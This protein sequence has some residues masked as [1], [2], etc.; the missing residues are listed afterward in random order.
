MTET[1]HSSH[2]F[3]RFT[4]L[5]SPV[6]LRVAGFAL[7]VLCGAVVLS[8]LIVTSLGQLE[9]LRDDYAA[10]RGQRFY[11]GVTMRASIRTLNEKLLQY[12]LTK[13]PRF[14]EEFLSESAVLRE[15]IR[16][17]RFLPAGLADVELARRINFSQQLEIL[18]KA[19][20]DYEAY[21]AETSRIL[22]PGNQDAFEECYRVMRAA[23]IDFV[24]QCDDLEKAQAKGFSEFLTAT[25][26]T[27]R[28]QQLLLQLSS[29][30]VLVL[31]TGLGIM[32]YRGMIAPLQARLSQSQAIIER[33]Q[34]LASLG[35]LGSGVA[36]EIRNPLTAIKLRLFSLKKSFPSML[37]NEDAIVI[38]NEINRLERIVKDFLRFARPSDPELVRVEARAILQGVEHLLRSPLEHAQ[39][40][41][42]FQCEQSVFVRADPQQIM[43]ALINLVQNAAD[44]IG[45]QGRITLRCFREPVDWAGEDSAAVLSVEDTGKG[46]P[47]DVEVRMFDPFF[48]TK[49]EGTGLGLATAARI[50]EKH[51]GILRYRT[52]VN[53]GTT[54]EILV[55]EFKEHYASNDIA[56]R[57]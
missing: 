31:A 47:P 28:T 30:L 50:I 34:R 22:E 6:K 14:R 18:E 16:T 49:E 37:Q 46:I 42:R 20:R 51:G 44:S 45:R 52:E 3:R 9:R 10:V 15:T 32:V 8:W 39:I 53:R 19:E 27:L 48:T 12:S 23:S 26:H 36:H 24:E 1:N 11:L 5:V 41:L 7:F 2:G 13:D 38:N 57:R 40:E 33:Q 17:N 54:F 29:G 55:P 35:L 56:Y 25:H 21:L 43:Q 4:R